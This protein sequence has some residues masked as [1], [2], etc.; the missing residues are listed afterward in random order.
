LSFNNL[1][2]TQFFLKILKEKRTTTQ[3][4]CKQQDNINPGTS[5]TQKLLQPQQHRNITTQ[6][7]NLFITSFQQILF[8]KR[9]EKKFVHHHH[10][11]ANLLFVITTH[12]QIFFLQITTNTFP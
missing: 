10:L 12:Q 8:I 3:H 2:N 7:A 11:R 5:S 4:Q 9:N 6:K 1:N